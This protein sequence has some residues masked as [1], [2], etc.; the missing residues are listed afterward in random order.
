LA[1]LALYCGHGQPALR[2]D[3]QR[4]LERQITRR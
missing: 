4:R 1:A 2:K 3:L